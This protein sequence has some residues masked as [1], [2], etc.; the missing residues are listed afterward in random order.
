MTN[1][2]V[3]S[4]ALLEIT[5]CRFF[6]PEFEF[7]KVLLLF[8]GFCSAFCCFGRGYGLDLHSFL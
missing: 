4:V 6:I 2:D 3:R 8:V 5:V 1:R 7:L